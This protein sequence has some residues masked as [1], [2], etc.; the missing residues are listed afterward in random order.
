MLISLSNASKDFGV[1]N[2]FQKLNLHINQRERLGLIGPNG[3]GKSTL[4]KVLAG[5]EPLLEGE[6]Q[7]LSSL[8]IALV[9]QETT[10]ESENSIL[11]EVL[12]GCGENRK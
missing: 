3:S 10:Y 2:L 9:G 6:R 7:S 5:V 1:K 4:L 12:A 11:E 8:R